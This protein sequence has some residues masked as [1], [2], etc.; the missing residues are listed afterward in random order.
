MQ[1][2]NDGTVKF[3]SMHSVANIVANINCE[4]RRK[5]ITAMPL[6]AGKPAHQARRGHGAVS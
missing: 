2:I 5:G 3:K 1:K 6:W 4:S